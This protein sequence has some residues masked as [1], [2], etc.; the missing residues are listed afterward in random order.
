[1][2]SVAPDPG[3]EVTALPCRLGSRRET[4]LV[5]SV[6]GTSSIVREEIG[7]ERAPLAG[8][9]LRE[10]VLVEA[11]ALGEVGEDFAQV[12]ALLFDPLDDAASEMIT[13]AS[14]P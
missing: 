8:D 4:L 14:L 7:A 2:R 11:D 6:H 12:A 5:S 10:Q 3:D 1:M 13:T 9:G